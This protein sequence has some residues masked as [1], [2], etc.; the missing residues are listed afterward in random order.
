APFS[1]FPYVVAYDAEQFSLST[2]GVFGVLVGDRVHYETE[3]EAAR[4][5]WLASSLASVPDLIKE[6]MRDPAWAA[7]FDAW[8][9][10]AR[11]TSFFDRYGCFVE[12]AW[13]KNI[14]G[15]LVRHP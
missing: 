15:V 11:G 6:K 12:D 8:G 5:Q 7:L 3:S 10:H 13:A 4:A 14:D 9:F 2:L 1:D